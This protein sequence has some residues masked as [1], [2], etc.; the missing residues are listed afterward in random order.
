MREREER[1]ENLAARYCGRWGEVE[2]VSLVALDEHRLTQ[3]AGVVVVL[4]EGIESG[5]RSLS[6]ELIAL[7]ELCA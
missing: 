3:L 2:V 4:R 1:G 7:T 6:E 5:S